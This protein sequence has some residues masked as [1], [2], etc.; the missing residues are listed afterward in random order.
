MED[1]SSPQ[2]THKQILKDISF[3]IDC[4]KYSFAY[5]FKWT[6]AFYKAS[7]IILINCMITVFTLFPS[8]EALNREIWGC[9]ITVCMTGTLSKNQSGNSQ[10]F[11][12]NILKLKRC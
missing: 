3:L 5:N 7:I 9:F 1:C 4:N 11:Q 12:Q 10:N 8:I 6:Q 2:T